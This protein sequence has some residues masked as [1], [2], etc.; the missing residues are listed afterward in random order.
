MAQFEPAYKII[1]RNEGGYI[2]HPNDTGGETYRGIARNIFPNWVG[3][4]TIDFYKFNYGTIPTNALISTLY[5]I[6]SWVDTEL[7]PDFYRGLW[8]KSRAGEITDQQVANIYFDFY[9]LHSE[10]VKAMQEA[11]NQLGYQVSIDNA[12]GSQ[13]IGA[14]NAANPKKLHDA[15]KARRAYYHSLRSNSEFYDGWIAR[16]NKFPTLTTNAGVMGKN[17]LIVGVIGLAIGTFLWGEGQYQRAKLN[18]HERN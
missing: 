6:A 4:T 8:A 2:N 16:N 11:L 9:V 13:T 15:Y 14:I 17:F 7:V 18:E 10:A 1:N 3:W 5:P 12:I